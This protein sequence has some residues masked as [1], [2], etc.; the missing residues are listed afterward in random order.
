MSKIGIDFLLYATVENDATTGEPIWVKVGGQRGATLNRSRETIETTTKDSSQGFRE[1]E[2]G[3]AEWSIDA[4]GLFLETDAGL[5]ILED[6]FMNG[7]KLLARFQTAAGN[8]YEG[9]TILTDYP[10]EAPYDGEVT[11]SITLEGD[12]APTKIA[13]V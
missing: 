9:F 4:D 8:K 10:I 12:G 1:K 7:E 2:A 13:A 11:Y 3:L 5:Q 6:A